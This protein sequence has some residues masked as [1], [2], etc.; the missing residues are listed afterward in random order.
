[1]GLDRGNIHEP[2]G[3]KGARFI[4]GKAC[5]DHGAA[6]QG[7][8]TGRASRR[9]APHPRA[10]KFRQAWRP[11]IPNAVAS[12]AVGFTP[13]RAKAGRAR[14]P[15]QDRGLR[16]PRSRN[17]ASAGAPVA[18]STSRRS[19]PSSGC[20]ISAHSRARHERLAR[21]HA[22]ALPFRHTASLAPGTGK[23]PAPQADRPCAGGARL[24]QPALL[25][26]ETIRQRPAMRED[27]RQPAA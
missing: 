11:Q 14:S 6:R 8:T 20:K 15:S 3:E 27:L 17:C 26:R 2:V 18:K 4:F 23:P 22:T 24:T 9:D 10:R 21:R 16:K 13:T 7:L 5:R 1:M 25:P 19:H 12:K